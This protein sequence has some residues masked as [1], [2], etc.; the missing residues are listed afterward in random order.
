MSFA[1]LAALAIHDVK[2]RLAAMAAR[3][4]ARGDRETLREALAAA[5]ELSRLLAC[6][7]ADAGLLRPDIDAHCP[8]DLVDELL[9]EV[10]SLS[11]VE[12]AGDSRLAPQSWYYDAALVRMVLANA[13]HNALRFARA[14]ILLTARQSGEW[15]EF[16]VSDDGPGYPPE[17]LADPA[18]VAP[19]S[20]AGVGL[21]LH[22]AL[23]VARLHENHGLAGSLSLENAAGAVFT[24]KLPR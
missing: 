18:R 10:R 23:S 2:N 19:M 21:G 15:L 20:G 22:L 1:T 24:L 8:A 14:R 17:L 7:K 9:V 5:G 4:E 12:I 13:L 3:A 11:G 16:R 6:Y